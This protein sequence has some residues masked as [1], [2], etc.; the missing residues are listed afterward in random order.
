MRVLVVPDKFKS[1]LTARQAARAIATGWRRVRPSDAL[2]LLPMTDG[3]DGFGR[4]MGSLMGA[5]A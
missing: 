5:R 2:D 1:T 3:G 4:I